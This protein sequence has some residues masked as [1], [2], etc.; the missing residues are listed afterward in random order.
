ME[1]YERLSEEETYWWIPFKFLDQTLKA[2]LKCLGLLHQDSSP[3]KTESSPGTSNQPE[4]EE[5]E[6]E[7]EVVM[8]ENLTVRSRG[9]KSAATRRG[10]KPKAKIKKREQKSSGSP[11][12]HHDYDL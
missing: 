6:E 7:E 12:K 11:G 2:I 8:E 5:E 3:T 9:T 4:E 10:A 1:K